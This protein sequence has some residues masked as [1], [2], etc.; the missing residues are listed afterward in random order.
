MVREAVN[1][2]RTEIEHWILSELWP[3]RSTTA[4]LTY[5]RMESQS[6][7][8]LPVLYEPL[9]YTRRGHWI[10]T[11]LIGAFCEALRGARAV[12]DVGP[13]DGWPCLRMA[14]HFERIVGIDS[15]SRRVRTQRQNA[16]RL[17]IG[18]VEFIQEGAEAMSFGDRSFGG[19]AAA[20]SIEQTDDPERTL[21]EVFRVLEPGR[22]L[23]M[24]FEDYGAYFP[25]GDGDEELWAEFGDGQHVLFYQAR[26]KAPARETKY[27]LFLD[28]DRLAEGQEPECTLRALEQKAFRRESLYRGEGA[29]LRPD[30]L[31]IRFFESVRPFVAA[32]RYFELRHFTS[33][34]LDETLASTGF[35][36]ARHFDHRMLDLQRLFDAAAEEGRLDELASGF[37]EVSWEFGAEAV[38][39]AG[40]GVGDFVVV[41]KPVL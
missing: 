28:G 2:R 30:T 12:L 36:N 14:G 15:S 34:S 5:E 16:A 23:A 9:D 26:T 3:E 33:S 17:H 32:A 24:V 13:G 39:S 21:R 8:L 40:P 11:A 27:G 37:E 10:D 38:R 25:D 41:D 18:N 19:V 29:P 20:S 22:S 4:D 31:G 35:E 6:G 7:H 1:A